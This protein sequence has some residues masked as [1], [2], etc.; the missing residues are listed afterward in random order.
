MALWP[1]KKLQKLTLC[2]TKTTFDWNLVNN[3]KRASTAATKCTASTSSPSR[4]IFPSKLL[5]QCLQQLC[6]TDS[7]AKHVLEIIT[8]IM[9]IYSKDHPDN[10]I[11]F[12]MGHNFSKHAVQTQSCCFKVKVDVL[13]KVFN[14][15]GGRYTPSLRW[16]CFTY[17][18]MWSAGRFQSNRQDLLKTPLPLLFAFYESKDFY[19]I[20][21]YV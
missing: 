14:W 8:I 16:Q 21:I 20:C 2:Q 17:T 10:K 19:S 11:K 7:S 3:F 13:V 1:K 5:I 9:Y 6:F 15:L 4:N 12:D 18:S